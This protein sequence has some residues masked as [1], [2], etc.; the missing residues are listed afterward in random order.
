MMINLWIFRRALHEFQYLVHLVAQALVVQLD[1]VSLLSLD[2]L[3]VSL[4]QPV[5]LV[6]HH[7]K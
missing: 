1:G 2:L 4:V 3:L 5:E 6:H 7:R